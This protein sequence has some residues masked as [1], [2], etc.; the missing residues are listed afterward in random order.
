MIEIKPSD[1]LHDA[2]NVMCLFKITEE[3]IAD[4]IETNLG[5]Y[6]KIDKNKIKGYTDLNAKSYEDIRFNTGK[7]KFSGEYLDQ[8]KKI[9][10]R[11]GF[12][13]DFEVYEQE[14]PEQP[15]L[16]VTSTRIGVLIAPIRDSEDEE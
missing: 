15:I 9:V 2:S 13:F 14:E 5:T 16:L 12:T 8:A 6:H 4:R 11:L 10:D 3:D 1:M 7:T